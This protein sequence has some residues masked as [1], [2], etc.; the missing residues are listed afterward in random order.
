[1]T[2]KF[3]PNFFFKNEFSEPIKLVAQGDA[4]V[5]S[6]SVFVIMFPLIFPLWMYIKDKKE[7]GYLAGSVRT[8]FIVMWVLSAGHVWG[9]FTNWVVLALIGNYL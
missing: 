4:L 7:A 9:G 5:A 3:A 8:A 1:L 2:F 6:F